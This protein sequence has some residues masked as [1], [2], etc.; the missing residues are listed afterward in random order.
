MKQS[1]GGMARRRWR[2]YEDAVLA[3]EEALYVHIM[4]GKPRLWDEPGQWWIHHRPRNEEAWWRRARVK[5]W[6]VPH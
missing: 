1:G 2:G 6:S 4:K 5:A 3:G